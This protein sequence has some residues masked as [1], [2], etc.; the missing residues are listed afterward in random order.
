M[1]KPSKPSLGVVLPFRRRRAAVPKSR[2]ALPGQLSFFD[3]WN[4]A[5]DND[6]GF[7]WSRAVGARLR[8]HPEG[9]R[10]WLRECFKVGAE[11]AHEEARW[12]LTLKTLRSLGSTPAIVRAIGR[13]RL[14]VEHGKRARSLPPEEQDRIAA[15]VEG[16]PVAAVRARAKAEGWAG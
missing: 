2:Q 9:S 5:N 13:G 3:A 14:S 15:E 4:G 16:V 12:M 10:E 7:G 6:D 1:T 8:Q 11:L